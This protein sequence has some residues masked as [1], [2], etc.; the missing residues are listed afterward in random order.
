LVTLDEGK[1]YQVK[2]TTKPELAARF[3][4]GIIKIKSEGGELSEKQIQFHGWVKK[5]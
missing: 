5:S 2:V 3:F 4:R 1:H